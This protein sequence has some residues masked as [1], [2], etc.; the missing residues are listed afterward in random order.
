MTRYRAFLCGFILL[1]AAADAAEPVDSPTDLAERL[2]DQIVAGEQDFLLRMQAYQ[3]FMDIYLQSADDGSA[4]YPGD[5]YA[6]GVSAWTETEW[7]G[8]DSPQVTVS[9]ARTRSR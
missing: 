6:M 9:S 5:Q 8:R 4:G 1:T 2:L 3:P 7:A